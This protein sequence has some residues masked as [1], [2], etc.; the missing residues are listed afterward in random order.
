[1]V[2]R[3]GPP[4]Q[5][6]GQQSVLILAPSA[7]SALLSQLFRFCQS[8]LFLVLNLLLRGRP[9]SIPGTQSGLLEAA[10]NL[11]LR[12]LAVPEVHFALCLRRSSSRPRLPSK[13]CCAVYSHVQSQAH[14]HCSNQGAAPGAK[15]VSCRCVR[16]HAK[17]LHGPFAACAP[18]AIPSWGP[19]PPSPHWRL[20]LIASSTRQQG[21]AT[22]WR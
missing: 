15:S 9:A 19:W 10:L 16:R 1:M 13:Q 6:H 21:A 18:G 17:V 11:L 20:Q 4:G 3:W 2:R 14:R 22:A 5:R 7:L 12:T 8:L